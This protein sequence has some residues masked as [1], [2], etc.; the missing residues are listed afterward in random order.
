M[1]CGVSDEPIVVMKTRPMKPGNGVEEKTELTRWLL[2]WG[3]SL[4]KASITCEGVK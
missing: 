1:Q 3:L 2:T 4:P